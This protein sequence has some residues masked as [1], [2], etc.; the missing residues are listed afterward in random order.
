MLGGHT[1]VLDATLIVELLDRFEPAP[2]STFDICRYPAGGRIGEFGL[3]NSPNW[4]VGRH[5]HI[6]LR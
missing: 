1:L 6:H 2:G 3:F 5:F 4:A